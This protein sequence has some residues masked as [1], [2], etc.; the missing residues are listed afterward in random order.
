MTTVE[1]FLFCLFCLGC[2][3]LHFLLV[4]LAVCHSRKARSSSNKNCDSSNNKNYYKITPKMSTVRLYRQF[5]RAANVFSVSCGD[6]LPVLEQEFS[7]FCPVSL[8]YSCFRC[9]ADN[10][11]HFRTTTSRHMRRE[12]FATTFTRTEASRETRSRPRLN[13]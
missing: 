7:L 8:F 11:L 5:L 6:S 4:P 9:C 13:W 10:W 3:F 12:G 1:Y 2:F